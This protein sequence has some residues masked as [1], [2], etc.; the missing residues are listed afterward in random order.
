MSALGGLGG[1][2]RRR[3]KAKKHLED[4]LANQ[5]E[6]AGPIA[7]ART[8]L[9]LLEK[10]VLWWQEEAKEE[11]RQDQDGPYWDDYQDYR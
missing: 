7:Q 9:A 11:A 3:S 2:L 1:A 5:P 10:A 8:R 4:L 6:K